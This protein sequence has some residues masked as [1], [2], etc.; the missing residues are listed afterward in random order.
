VSFVRVDTVDGEEVTTTYADES[1]VWDDLLIHKSSYVGADIDLV[2]QVT[3]NHEVKAGLEFQRHALRRYEH[4]FPTLVYEGENGGFDDLNHFGYDELGNEADDQ[5]LNNVKN[6]INVAGYLQDKFEWEGLVVNAGVRLDYFDY[7]TERLV[8]PNQPLDPFGWAAYADTADGLTQAERDSLRQ[9]SNELSEDELEPSE[10]VSRLSPRLGVAFPVAEGSVF[11][12]SY[13]KFFQRPDL[14]NL[15]VNYDYLEYKIKIGGYFYAFGNPNLEPEETTAYE[16]GWQRSLGDNTTVDITA[17]YKDVKN[18]TEVVTQPAV[19]NSFS[20]YRNVDYGTVK[21]LEFSINM[22]RNRNI[23]TQFNYTMAYADGTGSFANTQ[24]NIAWTVADPPKHA[25]PLEFDQRH[26]VTGV[27][28]LRASAKEGPKLGEFYPLERTGVNFV[29][30]A[31]S[32]FPYAPVDVYNEVTLGAISPRP[33][34]AVNSRRQPWMYRVDMKANREIPLGG[35]NLDVYF[36]IINVFDRD[37]V[38]DVYEGSGLANETGWLATGEG[39]QFIANNEDVHDTS[40]LSGEAKY[41]IKQADPRNYD[42]PRQIRFGA[43]WTF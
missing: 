23:S 16:A 29:F 15:Y 31:G 2:S 26:K 17:F 10:S 25:T 5:G 6:P 39:Q 14:Q 18:L 8:D 36:W 1:S 32:G 22:R 9:T 43:R 40:L 35:F 33:I 41:R 30:A 42:T 37:N 34:G 12:F 28:D 20:T 38:V 11:H 3:A 4:L 24:S 21:G 7:K 13:G 19:P 27:L